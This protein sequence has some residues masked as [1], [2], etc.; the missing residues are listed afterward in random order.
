MSVTRVLYSS[1]LSTAWDCAGR[2]EQEVAG[3][4]FHCLLVHVKVVTSYVLV[5]GLENL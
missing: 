5:L 3:V 2:E 1:H 4:Q